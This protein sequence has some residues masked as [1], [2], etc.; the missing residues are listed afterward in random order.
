MDCNGLQWTGRVCFNFKHAS[1]VVRIERKPVPARPYVTR[2]DRA[3]GIRLAFDARVGPH[4]R[5]RP[6]Q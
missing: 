3:A 1:V 6:V 5:V 4:P 2:F